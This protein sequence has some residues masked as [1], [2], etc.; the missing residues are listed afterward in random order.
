MDARHRKDYD[1]AV[2]HV[3]ALLFDLSYNIA[4]EVVMLRI[5]AAKEH[6]LAEKDGIIKQVRATLAKGKRINDKTFFDA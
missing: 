1:E 6:D 3:Y 4:K 5:Y 2:I